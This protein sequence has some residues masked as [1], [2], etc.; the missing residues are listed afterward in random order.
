VPIEI[1]TIHFNPETI[2]QNNIKRIEIKVVNKP[3][4]SRIIDKGTTYEYKFNTKGLVTSYYYTVFNKLQVTN[5]TPKNVDST[6][7]P[8]NTIKYINDTVFTDV[9]YDTLNRII[10]KRIKIDSIYDG[11]YYN[12][13]NSNQIIKEVHYKETNTGNKLDSCISGTRELVFSEIFEYKILSP[14]RTKKTSLNSRSFPYKNTLILYDNSKNIIKETNESTVS[15]VRQEY[16][17]VY[18]SSNKLIKK[19]YESNENGNLLLE[20]VY[21]YG[22]GGNLTTEKI[23]KNNELIYELY[24]MYDENGIFIKSEANRNPKSATIFIAK[25]IYEYY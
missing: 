15:S 2:K 8:E 11:Y 1:G 20:S 13:N 21:E 18:N 12:Y 10:C 19:S 3:D 24:F 14:D 25:Y 6:T 5:E 4:G 9:I 22:K 23:Y 16:N 7:S 17:Y